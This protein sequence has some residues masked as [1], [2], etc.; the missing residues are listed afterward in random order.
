[1]EK[2]Y[3]VK[4]KWSREFEEGST[5]KLFSTFEKAMANFKEE[6][7]TAKIDYEDL[8]CPVVEEDE[9]SF[10]IYQDGEWLENHCSVGIYEMEVL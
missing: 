2:V 1:M 10:E 3:A 8:T 9:E 4:T 6:V 5:I 7:R